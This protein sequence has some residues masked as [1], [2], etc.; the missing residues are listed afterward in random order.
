MEDQQWGKH[1]KPR[2]RQHE[3]FTR[4]EPAGTIAKG[5]AYL[6]VFW[7]IVYVAFMVA[8]FGGWMP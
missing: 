6:A 4:R 8:T 5:V 2:A 1:E 3:R 7:I